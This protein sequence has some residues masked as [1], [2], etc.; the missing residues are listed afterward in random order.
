M[1]G[2]NM[3]VIKKDRRSLTKLCGK[4]VD[5][6]KKNGALVRGVLDSRKSGLH[7]TVGTFIKNYP[8]DPQVPTV[9]LI[10][11]HLEFLPFFPVQT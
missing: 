6:S 3:D 11:Y 8:A 7:T 4:S 1:M 10:V 9:L 5:W 2:T